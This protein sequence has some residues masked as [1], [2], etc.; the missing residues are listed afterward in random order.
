MLSS[1][2]ISQGVGELNNQPLKFLVYRS[3]VAWYHY[4]LFGLSL[5]SLHVF[6][7]NSHWG[8]WTA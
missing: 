2:M 5:I 4:S 8:S 3:I 6:G 7:V 1:G